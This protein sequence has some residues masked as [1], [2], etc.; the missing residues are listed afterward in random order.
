MKDKHKV[1]FLPASSKLNEQGEGRGYGQEVRECSKNLGF[2]KVL[3]PGARQAA[4]PERERQGG[5][6][7]LDPTSILHLRDLVGR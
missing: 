2:G 1:F 5:I 4:M 3:G 7:V 6:E